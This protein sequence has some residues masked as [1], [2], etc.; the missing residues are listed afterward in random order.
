MM[1]RRA[2]GKDY[3]ETNLKN[4]LQQTG[5]VDTWSPPKPKPPSRPYSLEW[6]M[7]KKTSWRKWGRTTKAVEVKQQADAAG[8]SSNS[9]P[10]RD[11]I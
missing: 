3:S 1:D 11:E 9:S 4:L 6:T 10:L 2:A 7:K 8:G 5:Q